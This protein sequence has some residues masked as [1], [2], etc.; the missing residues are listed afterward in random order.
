MLSNHPLHHD[1]AFCRRGERDRWATPMPQPSDARFA[2]DERALL[3]ECK[4]IGPAGISVLNHGRANFAT[5][6]S[7][8]FCEVVADL[9]LLYKRSSIQDPV[10]R[11]SERFQSQGIESC[12]GAKMTFE[13]AKYLVNVNVANNVTFS[14]AFA[15]AQAGGA[16]QASVGASI[17]ANGT[18][19][20][21]YRAALNGVIYIFGAGPN[22]F[23]GSS[24]G[25]VTSG[26]QYA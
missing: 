17:S 19:G 9:L 23:P 16:I 4:R 24:A 11:L 18:V 6:Y 2:R 10:A 20:P 12:R 8:N 26:G 5:T 14:D 1:A 22:F 25:T 21:R 13:L 15:V 3:A 7:T